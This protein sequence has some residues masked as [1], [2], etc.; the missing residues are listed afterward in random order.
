MFVVRFAIRH[1]NPLYVIVF[2][3]LT[4]YIIFVN[5]LLSRGN[6]SF[7][8]HRD[9][10]PAARDS[11]VYAVNAISFHP[12]FGTFATAGSD[13][14]FTFWDKDSKQKLKV[15]NKQLGP[16]ST[17][18]FNRTGTIYAYAV[19]YDWSKVNQLTRLGFVIEEWNH[20]HVA[21]VSWRLEANKKMILWYILGV[22]WCVGRFEKRD[23]A[24]PCAGVGYQAK[25]EVNVQYQQES[26]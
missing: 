16:I 3:I 14:G 22:Y 24:V 2:V 11:S 25:E 15:F 20:I 9:G 26:E 12:I 5:F 18:A 19:S 13:G 8:C 10:A 4:G 17:A 23:H 21:N 6:F 1:H 7:R